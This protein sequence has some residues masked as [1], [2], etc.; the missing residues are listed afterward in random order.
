MKSI[1]IY[2][3][4]TGN[5]AKIA[6]AIAEGIGAKLREVEEL[7]DLKEFNL[8]C[9]GTP[10]YSFAP[11]K[12][13]KNFLK[14]LPSLKGKKVAGFCTFHWIGAKFTINYIR[15]IVEKKGA[16]FIGEFSCK[17]ESKIIGNLGPKIWLKGR[18]NKNDLW[19]AKE[20]GE[21]LKLSVSDTDSR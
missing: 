3:S 5:T 15:K 21:K 2:Y 7:I 19:R 20:F 17:G 6:T 9:I 10:V 12:K 11:A 16:Q 4:K 14:K 8:I 18:P 13:I 1:V